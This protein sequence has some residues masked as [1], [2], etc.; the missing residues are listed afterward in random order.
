[1]SDI[2]E[3][4]ILSVVDAIYSAA[5]DFALWPEALVRV[6]DLLGAADAAFGTL[7]PEA[8]IPTICEAIRIIMPKT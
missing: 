2:D 8:P 5:S 3:T 7:G 6:A 1:M 4:G